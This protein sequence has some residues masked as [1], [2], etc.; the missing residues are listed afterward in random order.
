MEKI[1]KNWSNGK[2]GKNIEKTLK[3]CGTNSKTF[4]KMEFGKKR[5]LKKIIHKN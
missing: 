4:G 1:K 5:K 3:N 2:H